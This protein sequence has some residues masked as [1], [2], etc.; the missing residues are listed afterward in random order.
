MLQSELTELFGKPRDPAPYLVVMDFTEFAAA[1]G[2]V[3]DY[4]GNTWGFKI[5]GH[6]LMEEPLR[7]AFK[8]IVD[9]GLDQ[10]FVTY[11]GCT[12]VRQ[13]TGGGGWSVHSWGLAI[14]VN[15]AWNQ[16]GAEPNMSEGF[17]EC[18]TDAGFIWGGV[19]NTPD[20]MHF[21]IPRV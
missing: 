3:K 7:Q 13:M 6:E 4:E 17:V 15:A 1:L 14:D 18:W 21:Q 16:Y 9:R 10:E 11:D 2:P 12:N 8:N 20:A 5:Y 19:W